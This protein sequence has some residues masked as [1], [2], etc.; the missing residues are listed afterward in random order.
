MPSNHVNVHS[1]GERTG[2][3]GDAVQ[4]ESA[5]YDQAM[6]SY[7]V[8]SKTVVVDTVTEGRWKVTASGTLTPLA[9]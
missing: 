2:L 9:A 7:K 8:N 3:P 4:F 6:N 5:W 1:Q